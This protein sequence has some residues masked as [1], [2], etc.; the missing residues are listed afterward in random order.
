MAEASK[1]QKEA[2]ERRGCEAQIDHGLS[3]LDIIR[4]VH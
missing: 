4:F 3:I 1:R 2:L